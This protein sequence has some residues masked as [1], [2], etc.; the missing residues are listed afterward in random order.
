MTDQHITQ[1]TKII[2]ATKRE[3]HYGFDEILDNAADTRSSSTRP[4]YGVGL[5]DLLW[6]HCHR[7]STIRAR[8]PP[9]RAGSKSAAESA[10]S[11]DRTTANPQAL[12]R[13]DRRASG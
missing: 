13:S 3:A 4:S 9:F 1:G 2:V 5:F 8:L 12:H 10:F 7:G 11:T 6:W